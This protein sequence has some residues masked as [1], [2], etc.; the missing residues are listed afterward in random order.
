MKAEMVT[1]ELGQNCQKSIGDLVCQ[2][3]HECRFHHANLGRMQQDDQLTPRR[4][5]AVDE[6]E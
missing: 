2:G 5:G 1:M 4:S 6:A 3:N